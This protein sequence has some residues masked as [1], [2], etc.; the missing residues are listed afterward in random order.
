M[1]NG[2]LR[3][4]F[5]LLGGWALITLLCFALFDAM[6]YHE[7]DK[8]I[9]NNTLNTVSMS[10][11]TLNMKISTGLRLGKELHNFRGLADIVGQAGTLLPAAADIAILD[12]AYRLVYSGNSNFSLN[13]KFSGTGQGAMW[14]TDTATQLECYTPFAGYLGN[15]A[16]YSLVSIDKSRLAAQA[17]PLLVKSVKEHAV[18]IGVAVLIFALCLAKL[19]LL[20]SEQSFNKRRMLLLGM[21]IFVLIWVINA[22]LSIT[23]YLD[24]YAE[25]MRNSARQSGLVLREDL[26]KLLAVGISFGSM[27]N[28]DDYLQKRSS[29]TPETRLILKLVDSESATIASSHAAD[30]QETPELAASIPLARA[31]QT[32]ENASGQSW[33]VTVGLPLDKYQSDLRNLILDVLTIILISFIAV[34]ESFLLFFEWVQNR[35]RGINRFNMSAAERGS[36]LRPFM[37]IFV[38]AMDMSISFIPLR[39]SELLDP[40]EIHSLLAGLPISVEVGMTGLSMLPAGFWMKRSGLVPPMTCGLALVFIGYSASMLAETPL[41]F[42][43]ARGT[44]GAGYGLVLITAQAYTVRQGQLVRMFAGVFAGFLCGSALGAMLADR[45]GYAPVFGISALIVLGLLAA[46]YLFFRQGNAEFLSGAGTDKKSLPELK[47]LRGLLLNPALLGLVF[48]N[49]IPSAFLCTGMLNYFIPMFLHRSSVAQSNIG[50]IFILYC[51]VIIYIGPLLEKHVISRLRRKYRAAF[52]GGIAGAAS[53]LCFA[54]LP[55]L[56][57]ACCGALLLGLATSCN[58]PGQSSYLLQLKISH[59]IGVEQ[60]MSLLNIAERVGQVLSPI[61]LGAVLVILSIETL[62]FFGGLSYILLTLL[63]VFLAARSTGKS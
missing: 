63:F 10:A 2:L 40:A 57:A 18:L 54:F 48:L 43:V 16:G 8:A 14:V 47:Q 4:K 46:P 35:L 20:K 5:I 51:L 42:I 58:V 15:I 6:L 61:C 32:E 29:L 37:F 55:P 11:S 30:I 56:P 13:K 59:V 41:L 39:M 25:Q 26:N 38:L 23:T 19:S 49:I 3:F 1:N 12:D 62:T 17:Y 52:W 24:Y 50:R 45:L 34:T 31:G 60:A 22:F 21:G 27:S 44:A 33:S 36:L 53:I 28:V 9:R 7:L